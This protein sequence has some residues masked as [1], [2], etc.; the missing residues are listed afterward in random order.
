MESA[1]DS[2]PERDHELLLLFYYQEW[3]VAQ[4]ARHYSMRPGAVR[5][6][7]TRARQRFREIWH[8]HEGEERG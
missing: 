6:R 4:L 3:S 8:Q 2:L 5:S 7:L 1:L